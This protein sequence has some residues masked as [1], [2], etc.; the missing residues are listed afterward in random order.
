MLFRS[1]Y[2]ACGSCVACTRGRPNACTALQV[3]GVHV[4]GGMTD[5]LNLP[6]QLL[7]PAD[8]L[9]PDAA[10][11]VEMLAIGEHAA[12]RAAISGEDGVLVVG[13]GPIGLG[14]AAAALRRTT[15]V[16]LY[17]LDQERVRFAGER[18]LGVPIVVESIPGAAPEAERL[19]TAIAEALGG[20]PD[21]VIDATGSARSMVSSASLLAPGGRLALVGH[22]NGPL[23]FD[24][25]TLHRRELSVLACRNAT[26][27][28]FEAVLA[29]LR[30]GALDVGPWITH[31]LPLE[32]VPSSLAEFVGRPAGLVKAL[33]EVA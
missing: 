11:L 28:D 9:P 7:V 15:R 25:Q 29:D 19:G 33:V 22:T 31:R 18:G 4:D 16:A 23:P 20:A 5:L 10:A 27:A 26:R 1:P 13:A 24:N 30:S 3:L 2:L 17:D 8:G 6:S 32:S 14:G 21:V 12:A